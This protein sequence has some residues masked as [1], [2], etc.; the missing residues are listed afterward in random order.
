MNEFRPL[1]T[2]VHRASTLLFANTEE[3]LKRGDR[4]FDGYMY[5][6]YGTPT[7]RDLEHQVAAIDGGTRTVVVP[8]GLAAIT[9]PLAAFARSG[10]NVL[11]ADCAYGPSRS[12]AKT[13]LARL[14]MTTEYFA[15]GASSIA[16]KIRPSTRLVLLESP[17]YY[18]MEIQDIEAIAREA[19]AV[20]A[21]VMIDN[22]WGFGASNMFSHGVDICCTALSKYASG[23]GDL[24]MGSISVKDEGL[25]R[26]LKSFSSNLGIGASSDEAYLVLRGLP[27]MRARVREHDDRAR[28]I[29]A[30]LAGHPEVE[31]VL[32]PVMP[33]DRYHERYRR[34]FN[35]GNGLVS[36]V[37]WKATIEPLRT[38]IDG[39]RHF[40]IGASWGS[41]HS[42]VAISEP[43]SSRNVDVWPSGQYIVRF[44][45]GLEDIGLLK[46]DI[47]S[48]L[49]RL[50]RWKP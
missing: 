11:V 26:E 27:S 31:R 10:G 12:F 49:E 3:F 37:L 8:S 9:L 35:S 4:L 34:F 33:A 38:M 7:T 5:G 47:E 32:N 41:S 44:H 17:G 16:D 13:F 46:A 22:T 28:E 24:C 36:V 25:F 2:G 23:A 39:F 48:G 14:G 18:T 40:R 6:L 15:S 20:G 43:A 29:C 21:L 19:H 50:A 45:I 42:L 1:N 30:W